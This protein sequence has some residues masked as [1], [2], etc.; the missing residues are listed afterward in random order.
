MISL[1]TILKHAVIK[2]AC[3]YPSRKPFFI[4]RKSSLRMD[5]FCFDGNGIMIN[6]SCSTRV[7]ESTTVNWNLLITCRRNQYWIQ[8]RTCNVD[9][10]HIRWIPARW[11]INLSGFVYEKLPIGYW[12]KHTPPRYRPEGEFAL[13]NHP[14]LSGS[15]VGLPALQPCLSQQQSLT[16]KIPD[17]LPET[18]SFPRFSFFVCSWRS[19][20]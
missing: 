8:H 20:W 5:R 9:W 11:L 6:C 19:R 10:N 13:L 15:T 7:A 18:C 17:I 12:N 16:S 2:H 3:C 14:L 4:S 1:I